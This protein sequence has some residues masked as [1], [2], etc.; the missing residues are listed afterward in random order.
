[1]KGIRVL[2]GNR[3]S[4]IRASRKPSRHKKSRGVENPGGKVSW[5]L[6][7]RDI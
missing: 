6:Y 5:A 7:W 2:L 4:G 1:M 3:A